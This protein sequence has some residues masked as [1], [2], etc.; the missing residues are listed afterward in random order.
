MPELDLSRLDNL[1]D[2]DRERVENELA[3]TLDRQIGII[4]VGVRPARDRNSFQAALVK[5]SSD[6]EYRTEAIM[7][8]SL[9]TADF[10]LSLKELQ[11]L[12]QVAVLSGADVKAVDKLRVDAIARGV[13]ALDSVDVSCCSCCCCCCGDTAVSISG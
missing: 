12:R 3:R 13:N 8:P 5:L 11:A 7:D 1:D 9:I 6:P 4:S 10:K 2:A